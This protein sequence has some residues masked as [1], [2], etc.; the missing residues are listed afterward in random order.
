MPV[1]KDPSG[2]RSVQAEVDVPGTP[3]QVWEAIATGPGISSWFVPSS[4]DGRVG[5]TASSNFGPGMESAGKI[6]TWEP[7]HRFVMETTE[8]PGAVAT[9]WS[10][11]A[12]SGD[13]CKVRVVHSWFADSDNW[14]KEFE[15]HTYG[16]AA[17]FRIL[18]IYLKHFRGL[19]SHGAQF[20]GMAPEPRPKAWDTLL[21][22]LGFQ[23]A[24]VSERRDSPTEAPPL[25]GVVESI[26]VP[27]YPELL[28]RLDRPTTGTA[29]LFAMSMGGQVYLSVRLY[30]YG[31]QAQAAVA[32]AEPVWQAWLAKTFA[33]PVP[34]PIAT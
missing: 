22:G 10:V 24:A 21:E 26:G 4:V 12:V 19:S 13:T 33:P 18:A 14:D 15:G 25:G 27:G 28:V 29:H 2:K 17:F 11:Q 20:N 30:L 32:Q 1:N 34:A 31:D 23:G 9:E 3:E 5:G 6:Q 8:G 16:W 7:P